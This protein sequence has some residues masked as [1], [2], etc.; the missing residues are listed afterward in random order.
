MSCCFYASK[1]LPRT[2]DLAVATTKP[3]MISTKNNVSYSSLP[4]APVAQTHC[5]RYLCRYVLQRTHVVD[6]KPPHNSSGPSGRPVDGVGCLRVGIS[7]TCIPRRPSRS[8][9][10][11]RNFIAFCGNE[12]TVSRASVIDLRVD[13]SARG[14]SAAAA[15]DVVLR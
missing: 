6:F 4:S 15:V 13:S 8:I 1:S 3:E 11:S 14:V 10:S 12:H 2:L 7:V 5:A 9:T